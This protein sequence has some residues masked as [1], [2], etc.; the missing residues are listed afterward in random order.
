MKESR[1]RRL[2]ALENVMPAARTGEIDV[3][4]LPLRELEALASR[5][6]G[7]DV[8]KMSMAELERIAR[9]E[10]DGSSDK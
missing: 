7:K 4:K 8:T 3:A 9:G 2:R 6:F 10:N 1:R 5:V